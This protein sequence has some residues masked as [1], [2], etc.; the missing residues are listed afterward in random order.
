[1]PAFSQKS[2]QLLAT[3]DRRLYDICSDAVKI[4]DFTIITGHRNQ[5]EQD[6]DFAAGRS[7]LQWPNGKHNASPSL[8]VDI[9]PYPVDW[10]DLPRFYLL[11]G[12][13]LA[14]AAA[15]GVKVRWGGNWA[16][17]FDLKNN[18]F[19]DIGHFEIAE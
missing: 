19:Q 10:N 3:V 7:K 9:A 17:D 6:A 8:A 1:M 16:G 2:V 12:I 13:I 5:A 15:R 18:K 14:C 11:A 4:M